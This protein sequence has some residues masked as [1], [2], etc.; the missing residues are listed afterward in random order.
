MLSPASPLSCLPQRG[1]ERPLQRH[2]HSI[3]HFTPDLNALLGSTN[4]KMT[5][6]DPQTSQ[7]TLMPQNIAMGTPRDA[8]A[9]QASLRGSRSHAPRHADPHPCF[10]ILMHTLASPLCSTSAPS[11]ASRLRGHGRLVPVGHKSVCSLRPL[12]S[13]TESRPT[14]PRS[15]CSRTHQAQRG[16]EAVRPRKAHRRATGVGFRLLAGSVTPGGGGGGGPGGPL[17]AKFIRN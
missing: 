8:R 4:D 2:S 5:C 1:T 3:S 14:C 9:L 6:R 13:K 12:P 15:Q 7:T 16:L 11:L 17:D 10:R